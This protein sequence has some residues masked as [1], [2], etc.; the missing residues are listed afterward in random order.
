MLVNLTHPDQ[1]RL[2]RAP[3]AKESGGLG[4]CKEVPFATTGDPRYRAALQ[5]IRGWAGDLAANPREDVPDA[6]PCSE[7][8]VWWQK[9]LESDA[10]EKRSRQALARQ[11]SASGR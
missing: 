11:Q 6:K 7:Y 10:I 3:L 4:L 2:L 9:R 5:V 8:M 1:S